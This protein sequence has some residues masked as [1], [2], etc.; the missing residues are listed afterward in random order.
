MVSNP[1]ILS[2][3]EAIKIVRPLNFETKTAYQNWWTKN[4]PD[5]L[6]RDVIKVYV[7]SKRKEWS[8]E[9][10]AELW[11]YYLGKDVLSNQEKNKRWL[12]YK[13]A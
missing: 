13:E 12:S 6:A 5:N 4:R 11:S 2:L 3:K 8:E 10:K 9:K 1:N 7:R